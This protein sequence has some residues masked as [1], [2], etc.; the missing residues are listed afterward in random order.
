MLQLHSIAITTGVCIECAEVEVLGG[1]GRMFCRTTFGIKMH[2]IEQ[3]LKYQ[4]GNAG[5]MKFSFS[6]SPS[7]GIIYTFGKNLY[8][9][10]NVLR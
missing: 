2:E 6:L 3:K 9:A 1:G 5:A 10:H 4:N 7:I 8:V